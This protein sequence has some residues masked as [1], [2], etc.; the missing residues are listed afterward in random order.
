[1][2]PALGATSAENG[3]RAFIALSQRL[4]GRTR[5][6]AVLGQRIYTALVLADSRFERNVRAL[7]RWLQ[8][9]GGVPSDIVTA[10]LKPES[11]E[12]A[13]AVSDV[14]RAWYLGL[15]GQTPNVR[16]LAYEKALMFDA[17]DD[18]L[19]IPSYC[20]DLPFYWALKPPDF[21]VPTASLD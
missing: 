15:I 19:T 18:V 13:A 17:V 7:N 8:G 1:M 11:P 5:F 3:Y 12:L 21:A 4:T 10:A 9:H 2:T 14:V 6:D 16:V 20:R